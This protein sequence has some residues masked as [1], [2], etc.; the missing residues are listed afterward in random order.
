MEE[1]W[2]DIE[3]FEGKYQISNKGNVMSMNFCNTGKPKL[4]KIKVNK[5]TGHCEVRLSKNNKT[6]DCMVAR[7]VA[8]CFIKNPKNFD[9]VTHIDN[10]KSNNCVGNLKWCSI[11]ESRY[12]MYKKGNRKIGKP[13][14]YK[15]TFRKKQY[16]SFGHLARDYNISEKI[17]YKRLDRHWKLEEAVD[18]PLIK[19]KGSIA[20]YYD[21]YDTPMTI[22]QLSEK[23]NI[24]EKNIYKRL[25]RGWSIEESVEIPLMEKKGRII[26]NGD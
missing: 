9:L 13:S 8:I 24:S 18:I 26:K 21:F 12:L 7:L 19:R 4:L 5:R 1:L 11:S 17:L 22:K 10:N 14:N 20:K 3:G 15:F 23:F 16:K 6:K 2:K 25:H